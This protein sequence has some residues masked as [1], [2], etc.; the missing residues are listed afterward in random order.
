MGGY[1]QGTASGFLSLGSSQHLPKTG[2]ARDLPMPSHV[3]EPQNPLERP[4]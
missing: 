3:Q 1:S 2:G 4:L